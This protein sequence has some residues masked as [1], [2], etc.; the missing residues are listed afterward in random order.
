MLVNIP[1]KEERDL[2]RLRII[3][4]IKSQNIKWV[5]HPN[6]ENYLV[7]PDGQVMNFLTGKILKPCLNI[8]GYSMVNV[9]FGPEKRRRCAM[10]HRLVTETYL[11]HFSN[12][13][14]IFEVN[15][16]DGNKSNN[17]LENLEWVTRKENLDHAQKNRLFKSFK[18]E[19]NGNSKLKNS[20]IKDLKELKSLGF[21]VKD[22]AKSYNIT[23]I[24]LSKILNNKARKEN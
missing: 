6:T 8:D 9:H 7:S 20:D 4:F 22:I 17:N 10:L 15:H 16:I 3:D 12:I 5:F 21:K 24:Y 14:N 13:Q 11:N 23:D 18:N 19:L 2:V 1:S